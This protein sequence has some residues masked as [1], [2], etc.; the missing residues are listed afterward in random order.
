MQATATISA[1]VKALDRTMEWVVTTIGKRRIPGLP[2]E[3]RIQ[4]SAAA[5]HLAIEHSM[6]IVVLVQ[7]T[8]FG[9]SLA[10]VRIASEAYARGLW[11][12]RAASLADLDRAGRDDFPNFGAMIAAL[13]APAIL[14]PERLS[15]FR[16]Q[17]WKRLNS[18]TH[19]GYQQLGA[20]LTSEGLGDEYEEKEILDALTVAEHLMLL[21]TIGFAELANDQ[22]L[23][24]AAYEQVKACASSSAPAEV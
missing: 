24:L 13:Q 3:K 21:S 14:G 6:S 9:S 18:Y 16:G 22:E 20:R 19:S 2:T 7:A 10:M 11:M 23:A 4:L 12:A 15:I 17:Q 1:K 8:M 5:W